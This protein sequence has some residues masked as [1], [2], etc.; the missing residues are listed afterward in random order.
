MKSSIR[1]FA[2]LSIAA[3]VALGTAQWFDT[4][5]APEKTTKIV[6][7]ICKNG[8]HGSGGGVYG[9]V[10]FSIACDYDRQQVV[11]EG[12]SG[13]DYSVR[14]GVET[15]SGAVDCFFTGSAAQVR[16]SCTE[17]KFNVR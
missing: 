8:Y 14:M 9:G 7:M 11:I 17:V 1:V 10:S 6:E 4:Q 15:L 2:I 16:E 12:V 5:A 3:V 13:T